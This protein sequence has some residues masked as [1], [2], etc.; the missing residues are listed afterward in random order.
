MFLY[1]D[2]EVRRQLS[3]VARDA[4]AVQGIVAF[5]HQQHIELQLLHQ[6]HCDTPT[7]PFVLHHYQQ[8]ATTIA[9]KNLSPLL[10]QYFSSLA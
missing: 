1:T 3:I 8:L 6:D 10:E 5:L 4:Q 2:S 7:P 9:R